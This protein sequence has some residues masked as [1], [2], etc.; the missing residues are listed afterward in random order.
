[1]QNRTEIPIFLSAYEII[2]HDQSNLK[3]IV[4]S[5]QSVSMNSLKDIMWIVINS[6]M[7]NRQVIG[8]GQRAKGSKT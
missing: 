6:E 7:S 3:E 5:K 4:S 2:N 8:W 1:M